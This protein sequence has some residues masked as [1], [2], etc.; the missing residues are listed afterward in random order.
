MDP[1]LTSLVDM[2]TGF[3]Q[4]MHCGPPL[5]EH[6]ALAYQ[7]ACRY[8]EVWLKLSRGHMEKMLPGEDE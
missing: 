8:L 7:Q 1:F 4:R 3:A 5:Q 2:A 6:E